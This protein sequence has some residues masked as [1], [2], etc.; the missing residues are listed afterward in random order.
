MISRI[1]SKLGTAGFV[2][3]IVA[4]VAALG[5]GAYAAQQAGLNGKQKKQVKSIANSEA[6][7]YANSNPGPTGA[8]GPQ[9]ITGPQGSKGDAGN[10]GSNGSDGSD[11]SDG[12][13]V[14]VTNEPPGANCTSGGK[15]LVSASGTT[16]VCNGETGFTDTLPA[17]KTE[18]GTWAI[19]PKDKT[20]WIPLSFNIPLEEAPESIYYVNAAGE[21]VTDFFGGRQPAANCLGDFENPTAPA[22]AVCVYAETE[23][24]VGAEFEGSRPSDPNL[25]VSGAVFGY[26]LTAE[27]KEAWGSWAVT[28]Q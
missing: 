24:G 17:G 26:S 25:Y 5:G 28:A 12:Q 27:N 23:I 13:S 16:Y 18:T 8:Q 3:A 4:L 6:K 1:H 2:V 10:P 19:G 9:G 22:G 20:S 15:K 21:E 7:K 11:G 14:T